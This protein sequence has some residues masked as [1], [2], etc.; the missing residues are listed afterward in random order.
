[1]S[2]SKASIAAKRNANIRL[3]Q[4][5]A[6]AA[7]P[8]IRRVIAAERRRVRA[9][10]AGAATSSEWEAAARGAVSDREWVAV[11]VDLWTSRRLVPLWVEQQELMGTDYEIPQSVLDVHEEYATRHG[12]EIAN[13]RRDR[14]SRLARANAE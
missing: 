6:R 5:L 14:Y 4:N 11:I 1:M 3:N 2:E 8:S 7:T 10:T 12:L 9:A 13:T